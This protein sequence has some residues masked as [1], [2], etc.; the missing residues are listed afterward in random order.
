MANHSSPSHHRGLAVLWRTP[1]QSAPPVAR[2][3]YPRKH[4]SPAATRHR[5]TPTRSWKIANLA[6]TGIAEASAF[7]A[8]HDEGMR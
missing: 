6:P 5:A 2:S 7:D 1:D 8:Q 3:T 4:V